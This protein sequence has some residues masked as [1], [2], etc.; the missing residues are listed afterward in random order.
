MGTSGIGGGIGS[1]IGGGSGS[2]RRRLPTDGCGGPSAGKIGV[3]GGGSVGAYCGC[4]AESGFMIGVS[5]GT[6]SRGAADRSSS[7]A[8]RAT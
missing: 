7:R 2:D 5:S 4:I 3:S 1:G 8:R 6:W